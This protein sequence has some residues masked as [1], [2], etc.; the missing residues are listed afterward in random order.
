MLHRACRLTVALGCLV[1]QGAL[2]AAGL[3]GTAHESGRV[4]RLGSAPLA[5]IE[6]RGQ[7]D[8]RVA[9]YLQG[10]ETSAYFTSEGMTLVLKDRWVVKQTF[11]GARNGV[12]DA[13][14]PAAARIDYFKGP[15]SAWKTGIRTFRS[16]DYRGLWP[17]IDLEYSGHADRLEYTFVVQPGADPRRIRLAY[18]GATAIAVG[19]RGDLE[20]S[21]PIASF[22]DDRPVGYQDIDG[23]RVAVDVAFEALAPGVGYGFRVGAYDRSRPLVIDPAVIVYAGYVGGQGGGTTGNAIAVHGDSAFL[24]GETHETS[25][26][27][28]QTGPDLT[29]NG[30]NT[31]VYIAKVKV[32]GSGLE[33]CGYISGSDYE[34]GHGVAVDDLGAAYVTGFTASK[35]FPHLGPL[36]AAFHGGLVDAFIVKVSPDGST[37]DYAGY[38][39]GDGDDRAFGIA[40]GTDGS[41]YVT[42]GT[43]SKEATFP[44]MGGPDLTHN[45]GPED[46][47]VAKV[48][49]DGS[50]LEYCGYIGGDENDAGNGIAVDAVGNA[51]VAGYTTSSEMTFPVSGGPM[52]KA[53]GGIFGGFDGFVAKVTADGKGLAYAGYIGG[54]MYDVAQAVAVDALGNAY[55]VG[56]SESTAKD[57]PVK[58]GPRT[59]KDFAVLDGDAFIAKVDP[60]GAIVYAGFVGG[61]KTDYGSGVGVDAAGAAYLSGFTESADFP[62]FDGPQTTL[63]GDFDAYIA[64]VKPD[65]SG[66]EYASYLGGSGFEHSRGIAVTP[67][68]DAYVAGDTDSPEKPV[69]LKPNPFP[70]KVGPNLTFGGWQDAYVAKFSVESTGTDADLSVEKIAGPDPVVLTG[71]VVYDIVVTNNGPA[72]ATNVSVTDFLPAPLVTSVTGPAV[73]NNQPSPLQCTIASL[74]VGDKVIL[75]MGVKPA[76]AGPLTNSVMVSASEPDLFPANNSATVTTTVTAPTADLS[77]VKTAFLGPDT[78]V[79]QIAVT[80]NGPADAT[81]VTLVDPIPANAPFVFSPD[82]QCGPPVAG[83]VTCAIG[84]LPAGNIATMT[85]VL[86]PTGPGQVDNQACASAAEPDPIPGNDCGSAST[87]VPPPPPPPPPK[88]IKKLIIDVKALV[89]QGALSPGEGNALIAKLEAAQAQLDRGRTEPAR[90]ALGAFVNEVEALQRSRRLDAETARGL[91]DAARA[92]IASLRG[93]AGIPAT[94]QKSSPAEPSR[95]EAP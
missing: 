47:F 40:V 2:H 44:V 52:L 88:P 63:G 41:A 5:F 66:L 70:V 32:D 34:E 28:L 3:R 50:G 95:K 27:P 24:V 62:A 12:P 11:T 33:Y 53:P 4:A 72:A 59:T 13:G 48:K 65:G 37:L 57:F 71:T 51:Y 16:V 77:V 94:E 17:G 55:V 43:T 74:A 20:V 61:V 83:T 35:D 15:R 86:K 7:L 93:P 18:E 21:T 42:G 25:N 89:L 69:P 22:H 9:Y 36:G 49:A 85:I 6:N 46:A 75:T 10:A 39:G 14:P 26:F 64:K 31:D 8:A 79:Y 38:L 45:G 1:T 73:C 23:R 80:N 78:I 81:N 67:G 91:I 76:S 30:G 60:F 54:D 29:F 58:V 90:N 68:G 84:S 92:A 82:P 56:Y 87:I 19:S